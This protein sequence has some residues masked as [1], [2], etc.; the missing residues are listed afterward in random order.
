MKQGGFGGGMGGLGDIMKHAQKMQ[1]DIAQVQETLKE[2]IVQGT[3]G[4]GMVVATMN[5]AK[6]LVAVK[7]E[8]EVVD[9]GDVEMLEDLIVAAV[10]DAQKK[11]EKLA[12]D[13]MGK[14]TGGLPIPGLF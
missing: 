12:E 1:K 13:E 9:P 4:G 6:Q 3:A 14:V 11:A 7:I 5:G 2:K 8:K 10:S